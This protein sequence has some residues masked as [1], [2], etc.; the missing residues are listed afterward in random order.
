MGMGSPQ[1][2]HNLTPV[3]FEDSLAFTMVS[4]AAAPAAPRH[5]VFPIL[6]RPTSP[7]RPNQ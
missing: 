6:L 2:A 3:H 5:G 7:L 1:R 4:V